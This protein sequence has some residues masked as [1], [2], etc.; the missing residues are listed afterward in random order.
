[1]LACL[2]LAAGAM[3]SIALRVGPRNVL[4]AQGQKDDIAVVKVTHA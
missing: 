1:M 4:E 3:R 2:R